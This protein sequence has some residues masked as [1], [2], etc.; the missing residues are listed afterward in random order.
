MLHTRDNQSERDGDRDDSADTVL[1]ARIN[2]GDREAF[3]ELYG[4]YYHPLLRFIYRM[5]GN[6][7]L[8]QE[9]INDVMLVVWQNGQSFAGRSKVATWIMGIAYRKALKLIEKSRR[10]T[11]RISATNFD[12][13]NEPSTD[14]IEHTQSTEIEDLLEHGMRKLS[15]KQRAVV[16][17]TYHYGYSYEEIATIAGCPVNT[18][19]TRMFHARAK[20]REALPLLAKDE[21]QL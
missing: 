6:L 4:K 20:L 15:A 14:Q 10:W 21:L 7:E 18:V 12:A 3:R 5:S 11:D 9:G 19:K 2:N 16:E 1:L 8:A 17:L 13:W